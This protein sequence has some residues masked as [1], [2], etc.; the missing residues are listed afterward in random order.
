MLSVCIVNWNTRDYL[1]GCLASL[2][3]HPPQGEPMEVIVVDNASDD[4]SAQMAATEFPQAVLIANANNTGYAEGNNQ[5]LARA[6]GD[7]LL[8][9]NPDVIV[10]PDAL[11]RALAFLRARPDCGALG[12]RLIGPGGETQRSVRGFPGPLP[13]L[14]EFLGLS[15]LFPRSRVLGAYRMTYFDYDAAAEVDQP[16]GTFLMI[17]RPAF[18]QV[19][20]MDPQFPV[21]F[22]EVDWCWRAKRDYGWRIWYTPDAAI[23]HYGGGSTRQVRPA[24]T[25]ESHRSLLRF[26][27]KHYKGRLFPPLLWLIRAAVRLN[28]W[29][30][31]HH[32]P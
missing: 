4:G 10:P 2:Y 13:V 6:R 27:D 3:A 16:M 7:V 15:R 9:L 8:L 17:P 31:T 1:R 22:N 30:L 28:E 5:A 21:F 12:C 25:R 24:M 29:R 14:W 19:G 23:T 18:A 20:P 26:Y 32:T 11:T